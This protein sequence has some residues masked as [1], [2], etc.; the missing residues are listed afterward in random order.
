MSEEQGAAE[1]AAAAAGAAAG[2]AGA[3]VVPGAGAPKLGCTIARSE[4]ADVMA[5]LGRYSAPEEVMVF[6]G[7][8]PDCSAV[9][10]TRMFSTRIPY[11]RD[12]VVMCTSCDAC[13][14]RDAEL[15]SGGEIPARGRTVTLAVRGAQ[16][17]G[18]DVIKSETSDLAI[19]EIELELGRGTLGGRVTTVEGLLVEVRD[20]LRR[21]RF[22]TLGDSAVDR[23]KGQWAGFYERLE[24]CISA[25][26]PFTLVLRDPLAGCFISALTDEY[27]EDK[28]LS[29]SEFVRDWE[30]DE[31]FGL[32]DMKTDEDANVAGGYAAEAPAVPHAAQTEGHTDK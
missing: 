26:R 16:D 15:R 6:P 19:P 28:Q 21:T 9:A 18:R 13:G 5:A 23:D 11:F 25:Q 32:H 24:A 22:T 7:G 14:Y 4:G 12:V 3:A 30:E 1:E 17:L 10:E 27:D 8:C 31:E 29:T 2:A 20:A